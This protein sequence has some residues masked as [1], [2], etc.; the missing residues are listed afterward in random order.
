MN[1]HVY[2]VLLIMHIQD[3]AGVAH[4]DINPSVF[5]INGDEQKVRCLYLN[6]LYSTEI[7]STSKIT[8]TPL[9]S[10]SFSIG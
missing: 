1:I 7:M 10:E 6:I 8:P 5:S 9:F 3:L 4:D 2:T